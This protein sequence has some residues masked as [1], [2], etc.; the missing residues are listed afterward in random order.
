MANWHRHYS[1]RLAWQALALPRLALVLRTKDTKVKLISASATCGISS[2][3]A[4]FFPHGFVFSVV[5]VSEQK[6]VGDGKCNVQCSARCT[7][8]LMKSLD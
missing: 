8:F 6:E 2:R 1:V 3:T 7:L 4:S 5:P